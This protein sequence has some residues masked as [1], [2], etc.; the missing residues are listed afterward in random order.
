MVWFTSIKPDL[1]V[2]VCYGKKQRVV[3]G[4]K[5]SLHVMQLLWSSVMFSKH[6]LS[7]APPEM[8]YMQVYSVY[9]PLGRYNTYMNLCQSH[10]ASLQP[11]MLQS[12]L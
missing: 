7:E 6:S 11:V 8:Y 5:T 12:F 9:P 2:N 3:S 10:R 1:K 4:R